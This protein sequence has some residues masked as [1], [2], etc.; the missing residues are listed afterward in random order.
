MTK[1]NNKVHF[2]D[3]GSKYTKL[4]T[5]VSGRKEVLQTRQGQS[6]FLQEATNYVKTIINGHNVRFHHLHA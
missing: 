5:I 3:P 2:T 1:F 4:E 6:N